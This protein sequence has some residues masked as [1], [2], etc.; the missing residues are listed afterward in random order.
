MEFSSAEKNSI[1]GRTPCWSA[2]RS[3]ASSCRASE[4]PFTKVSNPGS[5]PSTTMYMEAAIALSV[6]FGGPGRKSRFGFLP[7]EKDA[8]RQSEQDAGEGRP[9][10]GWTHEDEALA[11]REERDEQKACGERD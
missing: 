10:E 4:R 9:G 2:R 11:H 5:S 6:S 1:S 3:N 7:E 8:G